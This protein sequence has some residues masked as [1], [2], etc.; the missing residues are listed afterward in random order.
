M[1]SP[2]FTAEASLYDTTRHYRATARTAAG[3]DLNLALFIDPTHPVADVDCNT[4]PDGITCNECGATGPGTFNCCA[5][6]RK[7]SDCV[8]VPY[9]PSSLSGISAGLYDIW[10]A[11][12]PSLR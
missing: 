1:S 10:R 6:A 7:G 5:L 3:A 8:V 4:F 9:K 11:A 2:G 12:A